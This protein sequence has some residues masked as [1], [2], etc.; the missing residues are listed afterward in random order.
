M[1]NSSPTSPTILQSDEPP[2]FRKRRTER[3]TLD[4]I[5]EPI[6]IKEIGDTD[7]IDN[8]LTNY[9][10][11]ST[12]NIWGKEHFCTDRYGIYTLSA[13]F[14]LLALLALPSAIYTFYDIVFLR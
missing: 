5:A 12:D 14:G 7:P 4:V 8:T 13:V 2:N 6:F 9:P 10:E 3:E 1:P 11:I